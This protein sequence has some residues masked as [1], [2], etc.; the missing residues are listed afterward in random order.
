MD[1]DKENVARILGI[2]VNEYDLYWKIYSREDDLL[3]I[4][5]TERAP[6]DEYGWLRGIIVDIIE[7]KIVCES[8]GYVPTIVSDSLVIKDDSIV[9]KERHSKEYVFEQ[10]KMFIQKGIEGTVLRVFKHKGK[11]YYSTHRRIDARQSFWADSPSFY[12]IYCNLKG[13]PADVLF[14]FDEDNPTE[15]Y[16][17]LLVT[18]SSLLVSRMA[19]GEGDEH[20]V[21]LYSM[22]NKTHEIKYNEPYIVKRVSDYVKFPEFLAISDAN[23]WLQFGDFPNESILCNKLSNGEFVIICQGSVVLR[24]NSTAY[25]WRLS[26][27]GNEPDLRKY[28][29]RMID[30]K[31]VV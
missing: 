21:F 20:I 17:F 2:D 4:H 14:P 28:L 30:R 13:P 11:V 24:V 26:V 22:N 16:I 9:V 7:E 27:R 19:L 5:Y 3:L 12:D 31:S 6:L 15:V 23:H 8:G 10:S 1:K 18:K 29:F 25:D